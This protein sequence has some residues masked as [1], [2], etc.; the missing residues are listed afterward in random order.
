[1]PLKLGSISGQLDS[2][3]QRVADQGPARGQYLEQA[4]ALLRTIDADELREK[5]RQRR[6]VRIPW[7]VAFPHASLCAAYDAPAPPPD[8]CIVGA[9]ASSIAPERHGSARYYVLNVGYA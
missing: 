5:L 6:Q 3:A 4:Q 9:D 8:L 7:L 1:M 2:M